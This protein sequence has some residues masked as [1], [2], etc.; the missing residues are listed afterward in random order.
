MLISIARPTHNKLFIW[1]INDVDVWQR[2]EPASNTNMMS[3]LNRKPSIISECKRRTK[4]ANAPSFAF[5]IQFS[6][7]PAPSPPFAPRQ[8]N[9]LHKTIIN[10]KRAPTVGHL[11]WRFIDDFIPFIV[12]SLL[13]RNATLR[14]MRVSIGWKSIASRQTEG[15]AV[16]LG[17][18]VGIVTVFFS[19]AV[20]SRNVIHAR[21]AIIKTIIASRM[22]EFDG[23]KMGKI[24]EIFVWQ[25]SFG[26][27]AKLGIIFKPAQGSIGEWTHS[28]PFHLLSESN[29]DACT[30]RGVLMVRTDTERETIHRKG[31]TAK[32]KA[33]DERMRATSRRTTN[34]FRWNFSYISLSINGL[35]N[36]PCNEQIN[37]L[38]RWRLEWCFVPVVVSVDTQSRV[39]IDVHYLGQ[40]TVNYVNCL[41]SFGVHWVKRVNRV[42]HTVA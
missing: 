40:I 36:P 19:H 2:L 31:I 42:E 25:F 26:S 17:C 30:P 4:R 32:W 22:R 8:S 15:L 9:L 14:L 38:I 18:N 6:Q 41:G 37:K 1:Q 35:E 16:P 21:N 10:W 11:N 20:S 23:W 29:R 27:I 3:D 28:K 7:K 13:A 5:C 24:F 34:P 33:L 39:P 12:D